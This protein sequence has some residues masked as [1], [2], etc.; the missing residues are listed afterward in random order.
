M[1]RA[2]HSLTIVLDERQSGEQRAMEPAEQPA[3]LSGRTLGEFL[4]LRRLGIGGMGQ[5]YL[6]EQVSLKRKVALKLLR[7]ELADNSV[8]LQRFK[9]EA[10]VVARATH[11]NIVQIYSIGEANGLRFMALEYVEGKNLREFIEK[12]GPPDLLVGLKIMTQIAA[13]LQRAGELGI[14]HRDIKPENILLTRKGEVKV[15]DFGLS[16]CFAENALSPHIT[17]SGITMGTPLYMSP[18]QVEGK[19]VDHRTDIY[20]FG[21]TCYFLF[22]G[23]PPFRGTSPFEVALQ[24]VQREPEPLALIRPDLPAELCAMIH[25]MMAK[26]PEARYQSGREIVRE[27]G[28]LRDALVAGGANASV[29]LTP[30][31]MAAVMQSDAGRSGSSILVPVVPPPSRGLRWWAVASVVLALA[32]GLGFGWARQHWHTAPLTK[33]LPPLPPDDHPPP[34][35]AVN[36]A[37]E[38]EKELQ[39]LVSE[40]VK[41]DNP[42]GVLS[43]LN[44]SV[45]LGLLYLKERRLDEAETFFKD[46]ARPQQKAQAY[47]F[48][49]QIGIA[50]VLA[51][52][53]QPDES[54]PLFVALET[55]CE[56]L[57][58]IST[59]GSVFPKLTAEQRKQQLAYKE[60][61][62]AYTLL[63]KNNPALREMVARAVQANFVNAPKTFP[64]KLEP[65]RHPP[66]A[67]AKAAA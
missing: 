58:K 32:V 49:S 7:A 13:A 51:F 57:E 34:R 35:P 33:D 38:R 8:S 1:G 12:K 56:R 59:L 52:R 15:A 41:Q 43:G 66:K 30:A 11:A 65:L 27:I 53:D 22:A 16:R 55:K 42:L 2:R 48:L 14:I 24:H 61:I 26:P 21:V 62:E 29:N 17:Q 40:S 54:N 39:K 67:T 18:E 25:K 45:E 23:H 46:L 9:S 64:A 20:S 5:V 36:L 10:E 19:P 63:W 3:D 44:H 6:A 47:R 37:K 60:E 4:L 31:Q 28:R 50:C